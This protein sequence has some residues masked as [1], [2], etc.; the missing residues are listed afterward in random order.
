M[1]SLKSSLALLDAMC[2][3][4][5]RQPEMKTLSFLCRNLEVSYNSGSIIYAEAYTDLPCTVIFVKFFFNKRKN[6]CCH[7]TTVS[8]CQAHVQEMST[9]SL[10]TVDV[11]DLD[12][13]RVHLFHVCVI[14]P[15]GSNWE[16]VSLSM[17]CKVIAAMW[18]KW[19]IYDSPCFDRT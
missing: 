16:R 19:L 2:A 10:S 5:Q 8:R 11:K 18:Y 17:F 9:Y 7:S 3:R 13:K 12:A 4:L 15:I 6:T 14:W 1:Y